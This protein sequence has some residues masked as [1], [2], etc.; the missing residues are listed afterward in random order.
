MGFMMKG[1]LLDRCEVWRVC[2]CV[3]L[4]EWDELGER[5]V[6]VGRESHFGRGFFFLSLS[7]SFPPFVQTTFSMLRIC[8]LP[9]FFLN[10]V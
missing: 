10:C 1:E 8:P 7:L 5:E 9:F 4:V 2:M 3:S 6:S